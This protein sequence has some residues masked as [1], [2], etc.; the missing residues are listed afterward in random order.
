MFSLLSRPYGH[1]EDARPQD[2]SFGEQDSWRLTP[3]MLDS[4]SLQ[5]TNYQHN[6][7]TH[8][9]NTTH[10]PDGMFH[11]KAGDLHTPNFSFQ[12]GTPLTS[13]DMI[14]PTSA[15]DHHGYDFNLAGQ[16]HN[17]SSHEM[18]FSHQSFAPSAF[19]HRDSGYD[20]L[21]LGQQSSS[22]GSAAPDAAHLDGRKMSQHH[23]WLP[24]AMHMQSSAAD[25]YISPKLLSVTGHLTQLS[26]LRFYTTLNA[27]TAMIK[28]TDEIPISYLNKG[29]AYAISIN[30][31]LASNVSS[32]PS[33]YRTIVRIS[34]EDEEQRMRPGSCW[35][36]WKEGRGT[37]E[38]HQ[39][40]GRLQAVEYVEPAQSEN[41]A[42]GRP[43]VDLEMA[44][45]D[46]FAV[47]WSPVS[48]STDCSIGVR[49]NFLSTDF[50][51]SKGVKG[52]PVRLC[53][54]TQLLSSGTPDSRH[55]PIAEVN[56][57]K[58]KLFRDH[59]AERKLAN[60][61]AHIK[62]TIEKVQQQL[63]QI[64]IGIK[65]GSKRKR[66][67]DS[68]ASGQRP[69]KLAKHKRT[70]SVSSQTSNDRPTLDDNLQ[71]K[72]DDLQDMFTSTRP[73]SVLNLKGEEQDDP[74]AF[75]VVMTGIS[76]KQQPQSPLERR[77]SMTLMKHSSRSSPSKVTSPNSTTAES[78]I[79]FAQ[80]QQAQD[81]NA[82]SNYE[83]HAEWNQL[84][85][86]DT[87][88]Q[89]EN[90]AVSQVP[91]SATGGLVPTWIDAVDVDS[92]YEVKPRQSVSPAACFYVRL[93][94]ASEL[95]VNSQY[96]AIYPGER[97]R[98]SLLDCLTSKFD[99][100]STLLTN[101]VW[102]NN[103][104]MSIL[105]E[106]DVVGELPEGQDMMIEF[107]YSGTNTPVKHEPQVGQSSPV[108]TTAPQAPQSQSLEIRLF[109]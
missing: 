20:S 93:K 26:S 38:A 69:S 81:L 87:T 52:I 48:G 86:L 27:P 18:N 53:A 98:E 102:I 25:K 47:T 109:F 21:T 94:P 95:E 37:A 30:D 39:R 62:K 29:Q 5:F 33:R 85:H 56:Y 99:L 49:F 84:T 17:F 34:F 107:V 106:D 2:G 23:A 15:V 104:Q 108:V 67:S 58:V 97:T 74:D 83:N 1:H 7:S 100:D 55:G 50:S 13:S 63:A 31:T 41:E 35:Q 68:K 8:F 65:D 46:S 44:S 78:V 75:P 22:I 45:F 76:M 4:S 60:D 70:W 61:V 54:K 64:E 103:R 42:V 90:E 57:C 9:G 24:N 40:G 3:S 73:V 92:N 51:H 77:E 6:E 105:M 28:Q 43:R 101:I 89:F 71:Q 72:L 12:L 88:A 16:S 96:R 82:S 80:E 59:G 79:P 36:L 19:V 66:S 14:P 11:S 10:M 91:R 32:I